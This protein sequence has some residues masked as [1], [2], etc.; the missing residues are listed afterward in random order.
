MGGV[1]PERSR[2][3]TVLRT[4]SPKSPREKHTTV[5]TTATLIN[6]SWC[7]MRATKRYFLRIFVGEQQEG[8]WPSDRDKPLDHRAVNSGLSLCNRCG[9]TGINLGTTG[10]QATSLYGVACSSTP[11]VSADG[12]GYVYPW[13][14]L[15]YNMIRNKRINLHY[16]NMFLNSRIPF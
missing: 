11:R 10:R 7:E 14:S 12:A 3:R 1:A 6:N 13:F 15:Q 5:M 9:L 4:R 16:L 8:V 2:H